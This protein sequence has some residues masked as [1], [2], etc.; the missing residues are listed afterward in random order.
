MK[1]S[2]IRRAMRCRRGVDA[3]PRT[4]PDGLIAQRAPDDAD[5]IMIACLARGSAV[6][7]VAVMALAVQAVHA[8]EP[9][10]IEVVEKGSGWPVPLV[11]L[12]TTHQVRYITDNS[13]LI[14]IDA[15][16]LMARETWFSVS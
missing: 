11:E 7:V 5:E 12:R 10:V 8:A 6:F 4:S 15:P 9:C 16:E 13:G 2:E 1:G 3:A 14:V